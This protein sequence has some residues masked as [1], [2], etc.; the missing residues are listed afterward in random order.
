[1]LFRSSNTPWFN[2]TQGIAFVFGRWLL[3]V[4]ALAVA[5]SLARKRSVP[6]ST[7]T[8]PTDGATFAV[9]LLG[10]TLILVGLTYFPALSLG[11]IAEHLMLW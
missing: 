9:V 11:P 4:P 7:G 5:G 3:I 1:M 10:V 6:P 8:F 2:T